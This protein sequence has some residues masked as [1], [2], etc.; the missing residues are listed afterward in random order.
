MRVVVSRSQQSVRCYR[1]GTHFRMVG[2]HIDSG[3]APGGAML[4]MPA[5]S[6]GSRRGLGRSIAPG[7]ARGATL[8]VGK[9]RELRRNF[10]TFGEDGPPTAVDPCHG[11]A[12]R[13]R[14]INVRSPPGNARH[15]RQAKLAHATLDGRSRSS[16]CPTDS[17]TWVAWDNLL[18]RGLLIIGSP[19]FKEGGPPRWRTGATRTSPDRLRI[20]NPVRGGDFRQPEQRPRPY[21][22]SSTH[23]PPTYPASCCTSK[24]TDMQTRERRTRSA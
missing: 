5:R 11:Q 8:G 19:T 7:G 15:R 13:A 20:M 12:E 6:R 14:T 22:R 16:T 18:T 23:R 9:N 2:H 4:I 1:R 21:R 3:V 17:A 10:P 24:Y